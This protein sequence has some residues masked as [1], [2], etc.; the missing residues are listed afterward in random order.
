MEHRYA[1]P[2]SINILGLRR[3]ELDLT[4]NGWANRVNICQQDLLWIR[5]MKDGTIMTNM[6]ELMPFLICRLVSRVRPM[7]F[8]LRRDHKRL[9]GVHLQDLEGQSPGT[10]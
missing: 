4:H 8:S 1:G 2:K 3:G 9:N 7:A 10:R 5:N 6:I